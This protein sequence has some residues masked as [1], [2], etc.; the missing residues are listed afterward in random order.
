MLEIGVVAQDGCDRTLKSSAKLSQLSTWMDGRLLESFPKK[1][2]DESQ[3]NDIPKI[4]KASLSQSS[5]PLCAHH[6]VAFNSSQ[7]EWCEA[8]VIENGVQGC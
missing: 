7:F 4:P 1:E 2:Q 5:T 6:T 8:L 3:M